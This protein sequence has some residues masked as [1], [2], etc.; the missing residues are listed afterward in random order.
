MLSMACGAV[1]NA[2]WDLW[3]RVEGKPLWEMVVVR[4]FPLPLP[5]HP[6]P[7][8]DRSRINQLLTQNTIYAGHG[9]GAAG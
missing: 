7:R 4:T 3:A 9:A 1:I 6:S 2:V 5:L 8:R